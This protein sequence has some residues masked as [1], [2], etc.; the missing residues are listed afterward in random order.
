[1]RKKCSS[2]GDKM[3]RWIGRKEGMLIYNAYGLVCVNMSINKI[4]WSS[5]LK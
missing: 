1:M 3:I 5:Y 4:N 2:D